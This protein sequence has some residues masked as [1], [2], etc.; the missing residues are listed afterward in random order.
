ML[1]P[2]QH[3][4]SSPSDADGFVSLSQLPFL[5]VGTE[6]P[7]TVRLASACAEALCGRTL[8]GQPVDQIFDAPTGG[9]FAQFL[10]TLELA[11]PGTFSA[12]SLRVKQAAHAGQRLEVWVGQADTALGDAGMLLLLRE[13]SGELLN[14]AQ[15]ERKAVLDPLTGLF[16]REHFH[17]ALAR[18]LL[19]LSAL[20]SGAAVVFIDLDDFKPVNDLHGHAIGD[21]LLL[22]L[23]DRLRKTIRGSDVAARFGGDEFVVALFG[24]SNAGHAQQMAQRLLEVVRTPLMLSIGVQHVPSASVGVAY[25]DDVAVAA[26]TLLEAAD[27]AMYEAKRGGKN[28]LVSA[29]ALQT[30][31][32]V[33]ARAR[34][35]QALQRGELH[36]RYY[37]LFALNRGV[38]VGF[39]AFPYWQHPER[40]LLG[41]DEF[42][43]LVDGGPVGE[44]Y[45]R[46]QI[47][48]AAQFA[49][50]LDTTGFYVGMG[51]NL[52][53]T[54]IETGNFLEPLRAAG[55][56]YVNGCADLTLE[57][58]ETMQFGSIELAAQVLQQARDLGA[59]IVLDDFG[60]GLSSLTL[61][62]K[63]PLNLVKLHPS[64]VQDV[65]THPAQH[66]TVAGLIAMAHAMGVR[67]VA[68]GVKRAEEL[69]V[70]ND[71]GCDLVQGP[72]LAEPLTA[73]ELK[74]IYIDAEVPPKFPLRRPPPAGGTA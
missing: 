18:G 13:S 3:L 11:Q 48:A 60:S 16:N 56:H 6:L 34:F 49:G 22:A 5:W 24:I 71:L 14:Q 29:S 69:A 44:A 35:A 37:P 64:V 57:F 65:D 59:Y 55:H 72:M 73:E 52:T 19:D 61:L 23:A 62:S 33:S 51:L 21:E 53:R 68:G 4:A 28:R 1:S 10:Q 9:S 66:R 39:E 25:T 2:F 36:L 15:L 54:Q 31:Q 63:L 70:L 8:A 74:R 20:R 67:V 7:G 46:W 45:S 38:T 50:W 17:A 12:H 26:Q 42:L 58:L 32:A 40:G 27:H 41:P 43:D 30:A 47:D